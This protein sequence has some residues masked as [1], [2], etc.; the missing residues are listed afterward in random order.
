ML[1]DLGFARVALTLTGPSNPW[2][3]SIALGIPLGLLLVTIYHTFF[4][5]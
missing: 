1:V 3:L 2:W 4:D 5:R